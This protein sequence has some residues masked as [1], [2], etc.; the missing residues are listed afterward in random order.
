MAADAVVPVVGDEVLD[1]VVR[2]IHLYVS[3]CIHI[4]IYIY[5]IYRERYIYI[6][7]EREVWLY[8]CIIVVI[9]IITIVIIIIIIDIVIVI[10]ILLL[11]HV[12]DAVVARAD[13][14]GRVRVLVRQGL[15]GLQA[16]DRHPPPDL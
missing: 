9:M 3:M 1:A 16:L 8:M 13:E 11:H 7:I 5:N 15:E 2:P 14:D 6:Y 12:L 4:Y 10:L